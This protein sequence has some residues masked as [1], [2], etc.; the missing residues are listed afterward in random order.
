MNLSKTKSTTE[1]SPG[2]LYLN[3]QIVWLQSENVA[4]IGYCQ[5]EMQQ[6]RQGSIC[7]ENGACSICY[8][9]GQR[10]IY[11]CSRHLSAILPSCHV[12]PPPR[13]A[14]PHAYLQTFNGR[15][16]QALRPQDG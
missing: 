15:K 12:Q 8:G 6:N 11:T 13:S 10:S 3:R 14:V 4:Y 1:H 16:M 5:P 2:M 7:S 9:R